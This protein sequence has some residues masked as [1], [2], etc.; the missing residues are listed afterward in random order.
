MRETYGHHAAGDTAPDFRRALCRRVATLA[1]AVNAAAAVVVSSLT[2]Q[3]RTCTVPE[4]G[5]AY[6]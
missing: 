5:V 6:A 1:L 2:A 4:P 3:R